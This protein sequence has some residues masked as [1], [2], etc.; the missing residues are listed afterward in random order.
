MD[1]KLTKLILCASRVGTIQVLCVHMESR[2]CHC[3]FPC[4]FCGSNAWYC[5]NINPTCVFVWGGSI[6]PIRWSDGVDVVFSFWSL[7]VDYI[8]LWIDFLGVVCDCPT[9][10]RCHAGVIIVYS[11]FYFIDYLCWCLSV[12]ESWDVYHYFIYFVIFLYYSYLYLW[13]SLVLLRCTP[14]C[15]FLSYHNND[16]CMWLSLNPFALYYLTTFIFHNHPVIKEFVVFDIS[17]EIYHGMWTSTASMFNI[18]PWR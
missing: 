9:F 3:N 4:K 16:M 18:L 8:G 11:S 17:G 2:W 10:E 14:S 13:L 5:E 1:R 15:T 7:F 12:I 6:S